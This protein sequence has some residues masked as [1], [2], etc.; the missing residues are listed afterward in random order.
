MRMSY[1]HV[2]RNAIFPW[3]IGEGFLYP[4]LVF[5][6]R[7]SSSCYGRSTLLR[8]FSSLPRVFPGSHSDIS[9]PLPPSFSTNPMPTFPLLFPTSFQLEVRRG[10]KFYP[11]FR[12]E[13]K[14]EPWGSRE[15]PPLS[16]SFPLPPLHTLYLT[17]SLS[18][19][20]RGPP[21]LGISRN[22]QNLRI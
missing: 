18:S 1:V 21:D 7:P 4:R 19:L 22:A 2:L 11:S 20:F 9:F 17:P 3:K 8:I 6:F 15:V 5:F 10:K 12:S 16:P 13:G 14:G